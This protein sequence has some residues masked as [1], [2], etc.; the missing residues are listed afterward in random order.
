MLSYLA[1]L[2]VWQDKSKL[3]N[4]CFGNPPGVC[5]PGNIDSRIILFTNHYKKKAITLSTDEFCSSAMFLVRLETSW[6][7]IHSKLGSSLLM[8]VP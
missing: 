1:G 5:Q 7:Q 8:I 2:V 3:G 4:S 6:D